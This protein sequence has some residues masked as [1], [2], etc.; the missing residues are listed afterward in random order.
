[1]DVEFSSTKKN[2]GWMSGLPTDSPHALFFGRL[3]TVLSLC[4]LDQNCPYVACLN[5]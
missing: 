2:R 4:E 1:M 3:K 5:C